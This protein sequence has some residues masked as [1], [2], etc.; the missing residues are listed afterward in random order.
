MILDLRPECCG[1]LLTI[2]LLSCTKSIVRAA[3]DNPETW[4]RLQFLTMNEREYKQRTAELALRTIKLTE[5]L[6]RTNPTANTLGRQ[7]IRSA[8]SV[9]ASYRAAC[10]ARSTADMIGKLSIVEEEADESIYWMELLVT[11]DIVP[12]HKLS[13]LISEMN[14]ILAMTVSSIRT[15]RLK[16]IQNQKSKI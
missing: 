13:A 14:E 8:T 9:G 6:P 16:Q 7:L 12:A 10:R 3:Q 11:A 5:S 1:I 4:L 2:R 15:L